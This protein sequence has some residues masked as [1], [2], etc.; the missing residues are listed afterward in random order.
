MRGSDVKFSLILPIRNGQNFIEAMIK[1]VSEF[2]RFGDELL[3]IDDG[4]TDSTIRLLKPWINV[5]PQIRLITNPNLG[6]ANALNLGVREATHEIIARVDVDDSYSSRRLDLQ[7]NYLTENC[8]AVFSDYSVHTKTGRKIGY[9]PSGIGPISTAF[10]LISSSRTP[11]PSAVFRK[12]AFNEV[13]GYRQND[14]PCEDLSLW[15]RLAK[16]GDLL[17]VPE[18]LLEYRL[19]AGGVTASKK[20]LMKNFREN[21]I[22]TIG[23]S[24]KVISSGFELWRN[25]IESL[26]SFSYTNARR[27]LLLRELRIARKMGIELKDY[28]RTKRYLL[29]RVSTSVST[30]PILGRLGVEKAYRK[31]YW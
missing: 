26:D 16:I 28:D 25:E 5:N 29:S 24:D 7:Q 31:L 4:S 13:G 20:N 10:S 3:V 17:S 6:L 23:L 15:L 8:V 2:M 19:S 18:P 21:L 9:I 22:S 1:T 14:F 11:H 12:S 27:I 30:I